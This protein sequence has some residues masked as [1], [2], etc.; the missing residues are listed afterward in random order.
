MPVLMLAQPYGVQIKRLLQQHGDS[1]GHM[2]A[3]VV[4]QVK[5]HLAS[6]SASA[7]T[8]PNL[9]PSAPA[10]TPRDSSNNGPVIAATFAGRRDRMGLTVRYAVRLL[11]LEL[12][13]GQQVVVSLRESPPADEF[14]DPSYAEALSTG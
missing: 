12:D 11:E 7:S 5:G 4:V 9:L 14:M 3:S 8:Y 13:A 10:S 2:M 6:A 1:E